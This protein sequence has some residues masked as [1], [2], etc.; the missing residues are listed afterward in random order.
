M[1]ADDRLG[2]DDDQG[3]KAARPQ[4]VEPDPEGPVKGNQPRWSPPLTMKNREL[5]AEGPVLKLEPGKERESE[6][7]RQEQ[8]S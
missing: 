1:P 6:P 5:V 3:L 4:T 8:K 2:L 7:Y